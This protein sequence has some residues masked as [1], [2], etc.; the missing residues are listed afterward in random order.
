MRINKAILFYLVV[1]S[2]LFCTSCEDRKQ[3]DKQTSHT[4]DKSYQT[5]QVQ[6]NDNESQ[7]QSAQNQQQTQIQGQGLSSYYNPNAVTKI[8]GQV[9]SVFYFQNPEDGS[10]DVRL[11]V[12]TI[13]GDYPV[14][15]G[16]S[17]YIEN[18][19]LRIQPMMQ[20]QVTGSQIQSNGAPLII[21]Q[22]VRIGND[23][24]NLR[25]NQGIPLWSGW[26][27]S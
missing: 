23:I 21:A 27:R 2:T 20:V 6:D 11:L 15:L 17:W 10:N 9:V 24:L 22:Q 3:H 7:S 13:Q 16:P 14:V 26:K 18:G 4:S 1:S 8:Q 25:D 12:R 19:P 5:Q